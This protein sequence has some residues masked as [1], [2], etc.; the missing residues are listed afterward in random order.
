ML[1]LFVLAVMLACAVF[2]FRA[3]ARERQRIVEWLEAEAAFANDEDCV[4]RAAALSNAAHTI[5]ARETR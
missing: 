1:T 3:E 4:D 5:A 2:A